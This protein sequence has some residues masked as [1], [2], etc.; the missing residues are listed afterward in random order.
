MRYQAL[1][2]DPDQAPKATSKTVHPQPDGVY[3]GRINL[4]GDLLYVDAAVFQLK[5]AN[6][7]LRKRVKR[8][9]REVEAEC[10]E[11]LGCYGISPVYNCDILLKAILF[12]LWPASV[13]YKQ[14]G[15]LCTVFVRL[16]DEG[17]DVPLNANLRERVFYFQ[18]KTDVCYLAPRGVK[19]S[20]SDA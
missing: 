4:R 15:G 16:D 12:A 2:T 3:E 6:A 11:E 10:E 1:P 19:P 7:K 17:E 5:G 14:M 13:S 9:A 18:G 20:P 8:I